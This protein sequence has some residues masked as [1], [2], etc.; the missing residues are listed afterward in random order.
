MIFVKFH[1][2]ELF[3]DIVVITGDL[4]D[5]PFSA[6]RPALQPAKTF[7]MPVY[8]VTGNH[9]YYHRDL[10]VSLRHLRDLGVHVLMNDAVMLRCNKNQ[11]ECRQQNKSLCLA[12][13]QD[14]KAGE[15]SNFTASLGKCEAD[16]S[17]ILLVHQPVGA[18]LVWNYNKQTAA[19]GITQM[20]LEQRRSRVKLM[21]S[22]HTH[23]G[24]IAPY[25]YLLHAMQ[26]LFSAPF[27]SGLYRL[28]N[29]QNS[30]PQSGLQSLSHAY[31]Y[32]SAGTLFSVEPMRTGSIMEI[33]EFTIRVK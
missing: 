20:S 11:P 30:G 1:F 23:A 18:F 13:M 2:G 8:Y 9:E 14:L 22:G 26:R 27:F 31:V 17:V 19:Y 29:L 5:A 15:Q 21:L 16:S 12:G 7:R 3:I 28:D 24:Q 10:N 4:I 32:V 6:I 25:S 33:T